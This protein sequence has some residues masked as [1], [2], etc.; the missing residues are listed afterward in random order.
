MATDLRYAIR[1]I[2]QSPGVALVAV[3]TIAIGVGANAAIFSVIRTVLL[4]PR[5]YADPDR[6]VV[7]GEKWP[8]QPG[9][10]PISRL[11]Y[12]DWAAQNT[13]FERIAA[14]TW[15]DA[16]IGRGDD[17]VRVEGSLVSASYFEVF[18]LHAAMGRTF[19]AGED[20]PGRDHVVVLSH[21]LWASRFG[22]DPSIV[23]SSVR[24]DGES[25]TVIGVM[26]AGMSVE[27]GFDLAD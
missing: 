12:L 18:G 6:L 9:P 27:F 20:E 1:R 2:A 14:V 10:R 21:R 22:G 19:A 26:P 5:P 7:L 15:G 24:L 4:A 8:T 11:N 17:P 25:Y 13:V 3:L 23:G 16:T